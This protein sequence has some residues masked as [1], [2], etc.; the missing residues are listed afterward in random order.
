VYGTYNITDGPIVVSS[1]PGAKIIASLYELKRY[2]AGVPW[3]G[4]SE[5]MGVPAGQLSDKYLLPLYFGAANPLTLDARLYVG[6]P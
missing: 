4:Q 1:D 5:M 6:A 3:N 2:Q